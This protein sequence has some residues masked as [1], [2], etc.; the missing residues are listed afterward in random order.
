MNGIGSVVVFVGVTVDTS[1]RD[2]LAGFVS[3][4]RPNLERALVARFGLH[5]GMEAASVAIDYAFNEWPRVSAMANPVGYLYRVGQSSARRTSSFRRRSRALV[6]EPVTVDAPVD[7]DLQ[8]ALMRLRAD[9]RV[10]VVLVH[11]HGHSYAS[12]AEM[13]DVPVTTLTNHVTRGLARLRRLLEE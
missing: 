6:D 11:A 3:D 7:V 10:A 12:A 8:R 13:M 4:A 2:G 9:H 5:D 1:A